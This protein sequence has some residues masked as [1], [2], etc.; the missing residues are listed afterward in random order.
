MPQLRTDYAPA[1]AER[2]GQYPFTRGISSDPQPWIMGQY[3]G[4]GTPEES[5]A[6]FR[7]LLDAGVT[8]FSV[9]MDLPTQMGID[10]DDPRAAGEVGRV[11]VAI[12]SLA[13]IEILMR[14]IPLG[15]V[16]QV[17]TTANSIG[18]VWAAMFLVLA[19]KQGVDPDTFGLTIQNDVLKEFIARGTQIFP[20]E[21]SLR[22]AA[23]VIEHCVRHVP[24]W[25]PL[26]MSGYHIRESGASA[27]QEIAYTFANARAY[28]DECL[29]RGVTIDEIAPSLMTFLAITTDF[30]PEVAKFRAARRVWAKLMRDTY[31]AEDA[32]SQ[33][34][35][36][37]AFTA[38]SS[39]TAQ[40]PLNNVVRA[41][42]EATAA[43]LAG[44]QTMHVSAYDEALGVPTEA[45]AT[46]AL[47]TQQVVAFESG[48][49]TTL[50]P[51]GGSYAVEALTD[52][53]EREIDEVSRRIED[54]GGALRCIE[55]GWF[56]SEL[57]ESAYEL[58]Q[59]IDSGERTV[60]GVNTFRS[61]AEPLEV[62]SIDPAAEAAQARSVR[63]LRERR[64]GAAVRRGLGALRDAAA[65][66]QNVMPATIEAVRAYA[67][68]GEIVDVLRTEF[69]T[70]KPSSNF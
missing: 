11:G 70:W 7:K 29:G 58:A 44:V 65:A 57:S 37:F 50:D 38:G 62:F 52:E 13:D 47:R 4:F 56:A 35:K 3:A 31:G 34:L 1:G 42:L 49:T 18:Y 43:A 60:V 5:N 26:T 19:E 15:E 36:I 40:Q 25:V 17:R 61:E 59:S 54:R 63:E 6:R 51:F 33:Q 8:G 24:R 39:L 45:A 23:D 67:T 68:V 46:L 21:P 55:S 32:R 14:D 16:T 2:A 20:P 69:G 10:S 48:L 30:L 53:A 9:A 28:L 64:D 22:L 27:A 41:S 66:G 12:D